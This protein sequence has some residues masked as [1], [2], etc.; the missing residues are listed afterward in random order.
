MNGGQPTGG[1]SGGTPGL[2]PA[3]PATPIDVVP[4]PSSTPPPG[5]VITD[6]AVSLAAP[7]TP[8]GANPVALAISRCWSSLEKIAK[9]KGL[10]EFWT[11]AVILTALLPLLPLVPVWLHKREEAGKT[12]LALASVY[13]LGLGG[14]CRQRGMKATVLAVGGIATAAFGV[15]PEPKVNPGDIGTAVVLVAFGLLLFLLD[16][17][18]SRVISGKG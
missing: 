15:D 2:V 10:E 5:P 17:F 7:A 8:K 16:Q 4:I 11:E 6:A 13:L 1:Q 18:R 9:A 3:G 14:A 12:L